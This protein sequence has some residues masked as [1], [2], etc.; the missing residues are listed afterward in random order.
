MTR[1]KQTSK[2]REK[3]KGKQKK[4]KEKEQRRKDRKEHSAKG[5]GL[6]ALVLPAIEPEQLIKK[7]QNNSESAKHATDEVKTG[8]VV[9]LNMPKNYGFIR[10]AQV[11]ETLFFSTDDL[12]WEIRLNDLVTFTRIKSR[13]GGTAT[14]I[15]K[16]TNNS[17]Q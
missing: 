4:K 13:R 10:D 6:D 15:G 2:K 3:E 1:T 11:K 16:I 7:T 17:T 5:L 14:S 8:K 12:E 9:Y